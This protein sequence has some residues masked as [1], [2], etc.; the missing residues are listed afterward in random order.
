MSGLIDILVDVGLNSAH[1][2]IPH[3]IKVKI[4]SNNTE[5]LIKLPECDL[6]GIM[7]GD[8]VLVETGIGYVLE[9]NSGTYLEYSIGKD[10]KK[11]YEF[12][13]KLKKPDIGGGVFMIT[14]QAVQRLLA[15]D[16]KKSVEGI[17]PEEVIEKYS[18]IT[19]KWYGDVYFDGVCYKSVKNGPFPVELERPTILLPSDCLFRLD[20][21]YR[22]WRNFKKSN[23]EKEVL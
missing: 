8:R 1:S 22:R 23:E 3:S 16:H 12:K 13:P 9:K 14:K 17:K 11:L 19:G 6:T 7:F 5:Y 4:Y 2:K 10:R 15:I 20:I 18:L 21:V